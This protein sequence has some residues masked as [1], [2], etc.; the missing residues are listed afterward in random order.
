MR[1]CVS[2]TATAEMVEKCM[3]ILLEM[4]VRE[5][6]FQHCDAIKDSV[7]VACIEWI[8]SCT[9]A[10]NCKPSSKARMAGQ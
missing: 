10:E 8:A 3:G 7:S 9:Q 4:S 2:T 6:M 5:A 1:A